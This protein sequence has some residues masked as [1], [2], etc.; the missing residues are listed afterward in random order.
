MHELW[1]EGISMRT[2]IE[3]VVFRKWKGS[4]DVIA[5]FLDRPERGYVMSYQYVWQ[6]GFTSYPHPQTER[7]MPEEY[8]ELYH[9]LVG[10]GYKIRVVTRGKVRQ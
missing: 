4:G 8:A 10:L 7:A 5:F 3:R 9:E 2:S 6:L 1:V